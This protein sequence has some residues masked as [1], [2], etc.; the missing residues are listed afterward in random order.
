MDVP[1]PKNIIDNARAV[2]A[3][4]GAIMM[5]SPALLAISVVLLVFAPVW[6]SSV[7]AW[8]PYAVAAIA[9]GNVFAEWGFALRVQREAKA[10][11]EKL[12]RT[13]KEEGERIAQSIRD[14]GE[15]ERKECEAKQKEY[16]AILQK[17]LGEKRKELLRSAIW[18]LQQ[19]GIRRAGRELTVGGTVSRGSI[20][21]VGDDAIKHMEVIL[22]NAKDLDPDSVEGLIDEND[23]NRV[24][25]TL[26][27]SK[28][29]L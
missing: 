6:L 28:L 13:A 18:F 26:G 29:G 8:L 11:G 16:E 2:W 4:R 21:F 14:E 15:A 22:A 9:V 12:A 19:C 23:P 17:E 25:G 24:G 20:S 27:K 10:S 3:V 1:E 7:A 5:I